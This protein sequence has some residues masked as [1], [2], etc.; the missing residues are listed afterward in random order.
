MKFELGTGRLGDFSFQTRRW[1]AGC[2]GV[3]FVLALANRYFE[4]GLFGTADKWAMAVSAVVLFLAARY[5]GPSA[6]QYDDHQRSRRE[7][8]AGGDY[9]G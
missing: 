6:Q 1:I 3:P 4:W 8:R 7:N 5:F 9:H 2:A